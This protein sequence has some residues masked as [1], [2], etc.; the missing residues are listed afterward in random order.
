VSHPT[1]WLMSLSYGNILGTTMST[2]Y[3]TKRLSA[4]LPFCGLT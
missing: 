3:T 1:P 2:K 4:R